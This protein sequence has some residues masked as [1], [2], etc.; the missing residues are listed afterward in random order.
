[1]QVVIQSLI[2]KTQMTCAIRHIPKP[3]VRIILYF[4][5]LQGKQQ[6][7]L[8]PCHVSNRETYIE[9]LLVKHWNASQG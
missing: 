5:T 6:C 9:G 4:T 3:Q 7:L 1:M 8:P 2:C